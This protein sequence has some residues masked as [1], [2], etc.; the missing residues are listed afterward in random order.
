MRVLT[1][2]WA[3]WAALVS[4]EGDVGDAGSIPGSG[5][6]PGEGHGHPLQYSC[7][8]NPM[9][10]GAWQALVHGVPKRQT[11]LKLC[12]TQ[13]LIQWNYPGS[14][15]W[16]RVLTGPLQRARGRQKV[17]VGERTVRRLDQPPWLYRWGGSSPGCRQPPGA[18]KASR[19]SPGA[20]ERNTVLP[21]AR[22][23]PSKTQSTLL[24]SSTVRY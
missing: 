9:D 8:E 20:S 1:L 13:I 10:R 16:P 23:Q 21:E 5:R 19:Y 2:I 4:S 12:S 7:L 3:S 15:R 14:L 17:G 22:Y 24:I 6:S 18:G 11:W